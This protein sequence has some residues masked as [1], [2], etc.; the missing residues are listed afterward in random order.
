V[1]RPHLGLDVQ[2]KA[3]AAERAAC[4]P[5]PISGSPGRA[6]AT[7]PGMRVIAKGFGVDPDTVQRISRP[8]VAPSVVAA[9]S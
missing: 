4:P 6:L 7:G 5:R 1:M 9:V 3:V 8:F 2:P